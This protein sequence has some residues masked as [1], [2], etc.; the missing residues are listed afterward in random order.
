MHASSTISYTLTND[1]SCVDYDPEAD[2][3]DDSESGDGSEDS[4]DE[5]AA[6]EHYVNVGYA[7]VTN[8]DRTCFIH[9]A[10]C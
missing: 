3:P 2:A 6:T 9:K 4:A 10:A 8:C 1:I 7:N 5:K